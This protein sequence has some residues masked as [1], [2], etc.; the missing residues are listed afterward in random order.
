MP[1]SQSATPSVSTWA[2]YLP[3]DSVS[4]SGDKNSNSNSKTNFSER[5]VCVCVCVCVTRIKHLTPAESE[6]L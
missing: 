2:R 5:C 3:D 6:I 4:S 1:C